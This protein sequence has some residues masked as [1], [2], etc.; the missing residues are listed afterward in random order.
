MNLRMSTF[1]SLI[2]ILVISRKQLHSHMKFGC[3]GSSLT[4]PKLKKKKKET[5][6]SGPMI[7]SF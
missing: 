6:K 3:R 5:K 7:P 2:D 1:F 4:I